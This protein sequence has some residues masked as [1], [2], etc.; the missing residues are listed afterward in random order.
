MVRLS[1]KDQRGTSGVNTRLRVTSYCKEE[2]LLSVLISYVPETF[3][4]LRAVN[5]TSM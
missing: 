5:I 2:E 1:V 3:V 4:Q